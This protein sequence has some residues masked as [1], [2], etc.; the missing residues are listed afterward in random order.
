[1]R[2]PYDPHYRVQASDLLST[3]ADE[4]DDFDPDIADWFGMTSDHPLEDT[5]GG[6]A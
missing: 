5:D 6:L 4:P 1:M 2:K 3:G